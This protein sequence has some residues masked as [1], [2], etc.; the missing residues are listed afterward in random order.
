VD[1]QTIDKD[2]TVKKGPVRVVTGKI[3]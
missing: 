1:T 3:G 2:A